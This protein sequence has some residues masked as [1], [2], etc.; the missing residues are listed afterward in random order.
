MTGSSA[1]SGAIEWRSPAPRR[2]LD[3]VF[4]WSN[5]G[6]LERQGSPVSPEALRPGDFFVLPGN[7]GHTVLVLDLATDAAGRRVVLVGQSFMPAQ[8]FQVLRP[9]RDNAWFTLDDEG[10]KTPFWRT[11]PWSALRRLEG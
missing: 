5:T 4:S 2:Y 10:L 11:F 9:A 1:A 7:P 8:R 3:V 6:A